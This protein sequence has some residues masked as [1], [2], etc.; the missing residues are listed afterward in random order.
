M[1]GFESQAFFFRDLLTFIKK[2]YNTLVIR[3]ISI[4]IP[5]HNEEQGIQKVVPVLPKDAEIVVIDNN[6]T[7][8]TAIVAKQLGA[9]VV[10][11]SRPGYGSAIKRGFSEVKGDIIV[12]LDGDGQ[13]PGGKIPEVVKFLQQN[14]LDFV[15]CSRF[16]LND[17]KALSFTRRLGNYLLT[18]AANVLFCLRLKDSQ[19]G[20][21][22]FKRSVLSEIELESNSMSF[23]EEIK[24]RVAKHK[25]LRFSEFH[26]DYAPRVGESSLFPIKHGWQNL[27]YLFK[28]RWQLWRTTGS[29]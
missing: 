22:V 19:S 4:V 12:V 1:L 3:M 10:K 11:E 7:D 21:W 8:R 20:M 29:N 25:G 18:I 23:S 2:R 15:S 17:K 13:Y 6:C 14:N 26:I 16:P 27:V 28:L 24:I 5:C 9:Y